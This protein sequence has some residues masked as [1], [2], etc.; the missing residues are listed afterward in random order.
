MGEEHV[1]APEERLRELEIELIEERKPTLPP[2]TYPWDSFDRRNQLWTRKETLER[3]KVQRA[4]T[5]LWQWLRR[6]FT[7]GLWRN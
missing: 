1:E 2:S 3:A 6:V 5:E 4:R 7:L